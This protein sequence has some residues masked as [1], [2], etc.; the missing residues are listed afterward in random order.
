VFGHTLYF[1]LIRKYEANL[2]ASLTL[3]CPLLGIGLGVLITG[4]HF[5]MRM[6]VGTVVV[7]V[8]VLLIFMAPSRLRAA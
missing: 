5:D 2:I 8:G 1:V 6:G 7:L 3:M 4:D